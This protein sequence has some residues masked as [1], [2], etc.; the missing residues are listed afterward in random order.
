M[1]ELRNR[2]DER[3]FWAQAE[4]SDSK[5]KITAEAIKHLTDRHL[6]ERRSLE[7]TLASIGSKLAVLFMLREPGS[8]D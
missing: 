3:I 7:R 1:A 5:P 2:H 8:N 4:F 6:A